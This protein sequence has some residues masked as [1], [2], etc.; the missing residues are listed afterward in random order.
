MSNWMWRVSILVIAKIVYVTELSITVETIL[1]K[2]VNDGCTCFSSC[3][4]RLPQPY[5]NVE[6]IKLFGVFWTLF[7]KTIQETSLSQFYLR[8]LA[9]ALFPTCKD[10][11]YFVTPVITMMQEMKPDGDE[12]AKL[13][14]KYKRSLSTADMMNIFLPRPSPGRIES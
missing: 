11:I 9:R 4:V 5:A 2:K 14:C 8:L 7:L 3:L 10:Y 6:V 12:C 13:W 1:D